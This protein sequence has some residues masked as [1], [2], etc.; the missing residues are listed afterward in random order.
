[1]PPGY[2]FR[3]ILAALLLSLILAVLMPLFFANLMAVSLMKLRLNPQTALILVAAIMVGGLINISIHRITRTDLVIYHPLA[4]F[5]LMD[6]W[7]M[8]RRIRRETII[9]V[10]IGGWIIPVCLAGYEVFHLAESGL[11]AIV[12]VALAAAIN[13]TVCYFAAR[14]MPNVGI[15]MPAFFPAAAAAV[16]AYLFFP[17]L[18]PPI[19]FVV[20]ATGPII[21]AD[22]LHIKEFARTT[23]GVA[24]IGGA[25][26]FDGIILSGILAAY[27]A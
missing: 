10:N 16:S 12:A 25:G 22:V 1:M 26:T 15:V 21:G 23:T 27:L 7:P 2:K 4:A 14:P 17:T 3:M 19:A 18:A 6:F 8:L 9:A 13:V 24:S 20:G 5:G 11:S